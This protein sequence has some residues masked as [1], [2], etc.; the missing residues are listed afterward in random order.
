[1]NLYN[2]TKK[3]TNPTM[4]R[5]NILLVLTLLALAMPW[6]ANAQTRYSGS[7][8]SGD[9]YLITSASDW[10]TFADAVNNTSENYQGK[11]FKLTADISVTTTV[12]SEHN[13]WLGWDDHQFEGHFD[14]NG[15]TI[16]INATASAHHT[17]LFNVICYGASIKN[18]KV[19]GNID[20]DGYDHIGGIVGGANTLRG[21]CVI[22]NCWSNVTITNS[23]NYNSG[24]VAHCASSGR[25]TV[26]GCIFTGKL[27][28]TG[29]CVGGMF[30]EQQATNTT[31]EDCI[32]APSEITMDVASSSTFVT[33][34]PTLTRCYYYT[35]ASFGTT[36]GTRA[37]KVTF[38]AAPAAGGTVDCGTPTT[39]YGFIKAYSN[40]LLCDGI[41]YA[42]GSISLEATAN[43]GYN[44][45]RWTDNNTD[46]PRSITV[47]ADASYTAKFSSGD[48]G[49]F[50]DFE[51]ISGASS[52]YSSGGKLPAGWH[53]IYGGTTETGGTV[54]NADAT[55]PANMPHVHNGSNYPGPGSGDNALSGYY[56]GF[57]GNSS[58]Y[59]SYA[60]MPEVAS[61]KAVSHISFKYRYESTN[62]GTLTYG[63]IDGTTASTYSIKGTCSTSSQNGLVDVDLNLSETGGKRI[64]FCWAYTGNSWYTAGIDDICITLSDRPYNITITQ[65]SGGT[66]SASVAGGPST[67]SSTTATTGQSVTLTA[68]PDS[69]YEFG[70][71]TVTGVTGTASGNTYT[72]TMPSGNVTVSATFA[73]IPTYSINKRVY[74]YLD[75]TD[76]KYWKGTSSS[77]GSYIEAGSTYAPHAAG[78][79]SL[80]ATTA[81][82]G[83]TV[84]ITTT[85]KSSPSPGYKVLTVYTKPTCT[86]TT[87][88]ANSTYEFTM[89]SEAV[90]VYVVFAPNTSA[91]AVTS[92]TPW[93]DG[94][95]N[96]T[97]GNAD[98]R[99]FTAYSNSNTLTAIN[100]NGWA[101]PLTVGDDGTGNNYT[102]YF[103]PR[104]WS[105]S[106]GGSQRRLSFKCREYS[107]VM[108][109][110]PEFSNNLNELMISFDY[111][112]ENNSGTLQ[113]GYYNCVDGSFTSV[114]SWSLSTGGSYDSPAG[115]KMVDF[116]T[117]ATTLPGSQYRIAFYMDRH[118][119]STQSSV[120][121]FHINVRKIPYEIANIDDWN[122]FCAAVNAGHNYSGEE[123]TL[124]ADVGTAENP[125]TTFCGTQS[126]SSDNTY[127]A[128]SG[129][130][131]GGGHTL[132]FNLTDCQKYTAPFITVENATI[133]NLRTAG[134]LTGST[135]SDKQGKV[136][137]GLVGVSRGTTNITGCS[138][139]M[140]I[141]S[142]YNDGNDV[143]L[144]GIVASIRG[145]TLT[146]EGCAFK[147]SLTAPTPNGYTNHNGG[148]VGYWYSGNHIYVR[149]TI[150]A[151]TALNVTTGDTGY[152]W[153]IARLSNNAQVTIENCYYTMTLGN[154]QGKEAHTFTLAAG[155]NG[156]V[157]HNLS[158]V[159]TYT[160]S[161]I[162][163]YS[164]NGI[165]Y[166]LDGDG[167][168]DIV[169]GRGYDYDSG[170]NTAHNDQVTVT[171]TPNTGYE[172]DQ[173]S[174]G[175]TTST[176]NPY[177]YTMPAN[178]TTLTAT[179]K[180]IDYTITYNPA[181]GSPVHGCYV[182]GNTSA[183]SGE[184]VEVTVTEGTGYEL[185]ALKYNDGSDHD[186]SISSTPY[187]FTMPASNVTVTATFGMLP[188]AVPF[189]DDF[190]SGDEWVVEG[191]AINFWCIGTNKYHEGT[192]GLYI[193]NNS[194]TQ[195][196]G[197]TIGTA[198]VS[199]AYKTIHLEEGTYIFSY[200]WYCYGEGSST[201]YDYLRVL[202]APSSVTLT[203][204]SSS[205]ISSYTGIPSGWT[206][207]LDGSACLNQSSDWATKTVKTTI[208]ASG[209]YKL[210][211]VWRND[212]SQ[213]SNPAA[214]D[215]V[216]VFKVPS[217]IANITD[218]DYF[219]K[220]VN[221]GHTYSGET[222][223]MTANVGTTDNPV[224][225]MA[226]ISGNTF[227][228]T[229]DGNC[230]TL[231]V[232]ISTAD[233][234]AAPFHY[235]TGATI[236]DLKVTGSVIPTNG[237]SSRHA[238]GLVGSVVSTGVTINNCLVNVNVGNSSNK[239]DYCGG[240]IGHGHSTNITITGSAY[241]GT[242]TV[243]GTNQVGGLVGWSDTPTGVTITNCL[244]EC[245]YTNSDAGSFH[246]VGCAQY[247]NNIAAANISISN[248][249]YT[250]TISSS[251]SKLADD[252]NKSIVK[253]AGNQGT[254]AYTVTAGASTTVALDGES[255]DG[256]GITTP[257]DPDDPGIG[258]GGTIYGGS[259]E[260]LSLLLGTSTP[261]DYFT[262]SAST[263]TLSGT[264]TEGS[265]D[266]YT[267][268]M[269]ANNSVITANI[270]KNHIAS[271]S[272]DTQMTWAEFATVVTG[273]Q[274]YSGKTVYLDE[275][276]NGGNN[277][278]GTSTYPFQ[279]TFDGGCNTLT[280]D[281][282]NNNQGAAP[283][284]YIKGA[285]IQN[286]HV[287][288]TV[289]SSAHHTSGL[290][291]FTDN[292]GPNYDD[293]P[294]SRNVYIRNCHVSTSVSTSGGNHNGGII[295]HAKCVH[296][297]VIGCV[298]DGTI[299]A[300]G[301][302][303]GIIGWS[304]RSTVTITDTYFNGTYSGSGGFNPI[305]C[306]TETQNSKNVTVD[307]TISNCYYNTNAN[308]SLPN[309][310]C[311]LATNASETG[312]T[313]TLRD[314]GKHGYALALAASPAAGG[315]VSAGS[316]TDTYGCSGI[317]AYSTGLG[318][319]TNN[320][321]EDELIL[322]NGE[323]TNLTATAAT[324]YTFMNWTD[325]STPYINNPYAVTMGSSNRTVTANFV[326]QTAASNNW[327]SSVTSAPSGYTTDGDGNVTIS[328]A[329]GLAW[330]IS[331]VNAL[332]GEAPHP[333]T[334][335]IITLTADVNMSDHTW[336]P[337]GTAEHP[338]AG[339]FNGNGHTISGITRSDAFP[340]QGLFGY[341][342]GG[343][344]HDVVV[345]TTLT[346]NS[347]YSGGVA[348][349]IATGSKVYNTGS[350]G[351]V[352]A[353][354][355]NNTIAVGGT[356]GYNAALVHSSFAV[357]T[358]TG[359][360]GDYVGG[361]VGSNAAGGHLYNSYSNA[362]LSA[363]NR[364]GLVGSNSGTVENS[365]A[366]IGDQTFPA[367][368]NINAGTIEYCYTNLANGYVG[369]GSGT[370]Q[371]HGTYGDPDVGIKHLNYMYRDNAITLASGTSTYVPSTITY[372]S[373][374]T[375]EW[376]GLV[377][378]LNQ[379]VADGHTTCTK[380]YRPLTTYINGDLPVLGFSGESS[381]GTLNANPKVLRYGALDDMLDDF[382]DKTAS[383]FHYGKATGVTRVPTENV[384]VYIQ[385]DAVL[386][387]DDSKAAGDFINTTV[388]VTFDNS[389][390]GTHAY[391]YWGNK[392]NYDWHLLSTPLSDLKTGAVHSNYTEGTLPNSQVD[393]TNIGG[394]FPD[395]L[396]TSGNPAVGGTIKWDFYTYYEPEYHWINLKRSKNNHIHQDGGAPI[397]YNQNDQDTDGS[398]AY[399]IPGKGYEMAI[400]QDTYMNATG[401]LNRGNVPITLTNSEPD[402]INYAKGWNLVGN[403]YQ[404]YLDIDK[405]GY[406]PIYTYDAD[407]GTFVPYTT[408]ASENP[409][410]VS[411]YIHPHQAFFVQASSNN[412]ELLFTQT[413]ATTDSEPGSY[414]RDD[415]VN[416]PL[417]NLFAEDETGHRDLTVVE[418]HRPELGGAAK[419]DYMRTAPFSLAAH[420]S[421][422]SYGILFATDDIERV[423][424]HFKPAADGLITLSWSTHNGEF[425]LLKLVDNKLGVEH[426]MLA[427]NSYSFMASADDYSSRFY[428]TYECSGMGIDENDEGG[429]ST[430][431][432]TFAY[433]NNGN[434]VVD[435]GAGHGASLQVIDVLGRVL[436]SQEGLE[437]A[438]TV[439]TSGLAKGVYILRLS[440]NQGIKTQKIVVQ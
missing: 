185:T 248:C 436:Y 174:D 354:S 81:T 414:F 350:T 144:S 364:G 299:T 298:Y 356:V 57:H 229:F 46:N 42:N 179:F 23:A 137:A 334:D 153:T 418:F 127:T 201:R 9:P 120:N 131:L 408:S 245:T 258:V 222:V 264:A 329:N 165:G 224:T 16:T 29:Q 332:N 209:D 5:R 297:H 435:V 250:Y 194:S 375:P 178:N 48:C 207:A 257:D 370:L 124:T 289:S 203:D 228:G 421:G 89:P 344:I 80:S 94:F 398:S 412:E 320:D 217:T 301:Y 122:A 154:V 19:E 37:Y 226:G 218:W 273:G 324:G 437:G 28:G 374:H 106:T 308:N 319:D 13:I 56:L 24:I 346:G 240:L 396:I 147:G 103:S 335:T 66:I 136:H 21:D 230:K 380:W 415:K 336:V 239:T 79:V 93:T 216:E 272:S 367:F 438:C 387:Q 115:S 309:K 15:H 307:L 368:A 381:L 78:S 190:E 188:V 348:G 146:V 341:V 403:P 263:G 295:G 383:I 87:V 254:P 362:T 17:G 274:T 276:V 70:S 371:Y 369:G 101:L 92:S 33:S 82:A 429:A 212:G 181:S 25:V 400:S 393:I 233:E 76:Y 193:T 54:Y 104:F 265:D 67:T 424:V 373:N 200:D 391:D 125:I 32:F 198:A 152:S 160:G 149:N 59:Y 199:F 253:N 269:T 72:F 268:Q 397:H 167:T 8:T 86:I 210:V 326:N 288:G 339:T 404:A 126:V 69:G 100:D 392:L 158:T 50:E 279:G 215:N 184:T 77:G 84:T 242:L 290:V 163:V 357:G 266:P 145:G 14:G 232:N 73:L 296:N 71:W 395:G 112:V 300:T 376:N 231:S 256:V 406:D 63:V 303:G 401:T 325:G 161:G 388:G 361:L 173:W 97:W 1:M 95:D 327:V 39:N 310:H 378:A 169:L 186:I 88:S 38:A 204:A 351:T 322:G 123:V 98:S 244:S 155:A 423:P 316:S 117:V 377:S 365:Y 252:D 317:T 129:T 328:D 294:L 187:T 312:G 405:I 411:Q 379:W 74:P 287:T 3:L 31:F 338:F 330:L 416:Y 53:R 189:S 349:Y 141:S 22:E 202:L 302:T 65:P 206:A 211:F 389:D 168:G 321:G 44:F 151:P 282:T 26:R 133:Q 83:S 183:H 359:Q 30:G 235:V 176:S 7:G 247:G 291:G 333:F 426:N 439:S 386:L 286:L 205:F 384:H 410:I 340:Y 162:T 121:L 285:T 113:V 331:K 315:T 342:E 432:A 434:I 12:G 175:S 278:V 345:N 96:M 43:D 270:L 214:I 143:A 109:C 61:G 413:M 139:T 34:S 116:S 118:A 260:T 262:Y 292:E 251:G 277:P 372:A 343:T 234:F 281:I 431:S 208:A 390:H 60:I 353:P 358:I 18:L 259:G 417:V 394:Y 68:T 360:T 11:Y 128:F 10:N 284:Q 132:T 55:T 420:Y 102:R 27:K 36:Q 223:T 90:T 105:S 241:T 20:G 382:R 419:L 422:K 275:D 219:A 305:G 227:Q 150:F 283:F 45:I 237:T 196:Y 156:S 385:E 111:A 425:S 197:Y 191:S 407:Q 311:I 313:W 52:G 213:G 41:Y 255:C 75:G 366:A 99:S 138:S 314:L 177:T 172:L 280:V 347:N 363:G 58:S 271:T 352:S 164:P 51:G 108:A 433:I 409:E 195:A 159:A 399:Y 430:G 306:K 166:D 323:S 192:H 35:D 428:I 157:S 243:S 47:S 130:F 170:T 4:K 171:A 267:L 40:G 114:Q 427:D 220:A 85:P 148:I 135:S 107:E 64:A 62:N 225:T 246:P 236:Q 49:D 110:L 440:S 6:A 249:Y 238:G 142:S 304:D 318:Y 293:A 337:I 182:T 91:T 261:V 140:A 119:A 402:D 355:D 134:S 2:T 221:A 180:P